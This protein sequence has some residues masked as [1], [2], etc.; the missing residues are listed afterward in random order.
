MSFSFS[1]KIKFSVV[2]IG[3]NCTSLPGLGENKA[4]FGIKLG[5]KFFYR[6]NSISKI[7]LHSGRAILFPGWGMLP[8]ISFF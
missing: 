1:N 2:V 3:D 8:L 7:I 4:A 6:L 5:L